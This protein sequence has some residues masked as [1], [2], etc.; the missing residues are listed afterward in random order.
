MPDATP[1]PSDDD[2]V[3]TYR[4]REKAADESAQWH[5]VAAGAGEFVGSI[6]GGAA[7]GYLLDLAFGTWPWL[8]V[9]GLLLGFVAGLILLVRLAGKAFK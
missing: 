5:K 3:A 9:V 6:L 8:M 7:L 2:F 4:A 1:P